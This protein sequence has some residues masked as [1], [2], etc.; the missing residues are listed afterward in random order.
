MAFFLLCGLTLLFAI[1]G[2]IWVLHLDKRDKQ[3]EQQAAHDA[4]N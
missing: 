4:N 3:R 1:V 2:T